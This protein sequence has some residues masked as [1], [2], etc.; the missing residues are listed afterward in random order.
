MEGTYFHLTSMKTYLMASL[1]TQRAETDPLEVDVIQCGSLG[2]GAS[3]HSL[4]QHLAAMG[5]TASNQYQLRL[6]Q[7]VGRKVSTKRIDAN[8]PGKAEDEDGLFSSW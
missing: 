4:P 5:Q 3:V 6:R 2:H 7:L 1:R 8:L